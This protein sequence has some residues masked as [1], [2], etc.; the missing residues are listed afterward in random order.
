MDLWADLKANPGAV[1]ADAL[2]TELAK[3][4]GFITR[5]AKGVGL[6]KIKVGGLEMTLDNIGKG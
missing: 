5:A 1:I 2:R 4:D 3:F 6:D